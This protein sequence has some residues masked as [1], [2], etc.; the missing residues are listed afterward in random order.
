[1]ITLGWQLVIERLIKL[2]TLLAL[3][4]WFQQ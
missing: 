1:L 3:A 2:N 4:A